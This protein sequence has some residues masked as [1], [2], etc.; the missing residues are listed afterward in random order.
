[1]H[2]YNGDGSGLASPSAV[3]FL[4]R[5]TKLKKEVQVTHT[6]TGGGSHP[7]LIGM[8]YLCCTKITL[9]DPHIL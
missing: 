4:F 6:D 1:M 5:P 3:A 7:P 9:P 2:H 8:V